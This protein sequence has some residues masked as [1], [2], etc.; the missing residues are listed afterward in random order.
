[1]NTD[2]RI[3]DDEGNDLP[4]G[5]IGMIHV[6]RPGQ[7]AP[8]FTYLGDVP[9]GTGADGFTVLGDLGRLDQDGYLY[10]ADRRVDMIISG[11][12]NV[13]PAEV[14][15]ALTEHT[16]VAD[17]AVVGL[18]DDEWGERV[19]AIVVVADGAEPPTIDDLRMFCRER[20]A[21][22]KVPKTIEIVARLPRTEAGKIRRGDLVKERTSQPG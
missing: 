9:S 21:A 6:R 17:A 4:V 5:E 2:L 13:F 19:H 20:L 10:L 16:L 14:E 3:R 8:V 11:G 18:P 22:Y 12:A 1:M 7:S 15:G